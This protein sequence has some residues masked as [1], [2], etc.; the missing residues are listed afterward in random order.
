M[1]RNQGVQIKANDAKILLENPILKSAFADVREM[2]V[3]A[4]E[5]NPVTNETQRDKIMLS[6][7]LL[8][9]VKEQIEKHVQ[10]GQID[11]INMEVF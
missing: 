1:S 3:Q 6:L 10:D 11:K 5:D 9:S 2:L 7:Q 8:R 4:I